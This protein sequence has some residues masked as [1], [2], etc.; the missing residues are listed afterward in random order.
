M[1]IHPTDFRDDMT[2]TQGVLLRKK[3][4]LQLGW[5]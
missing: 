1:A 4:I 3:M 2:E 5:S